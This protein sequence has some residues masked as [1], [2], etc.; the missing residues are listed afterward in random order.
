MTREEPNKGYSFMLH[1]RMRKAP[2]RLGDFVWLDMPKLSWTC[3]KGASVCAAD[4]LCEK[5]AA[6]DS[7]QVCGLRVGEISSSHENKK[8]YISI[9]TKKKR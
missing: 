2:V 1:N 9:E 4:V 7:T 6:E 5:D 3:R 8:I